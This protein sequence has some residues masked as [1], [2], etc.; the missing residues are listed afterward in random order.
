MEGEAWENV[1]DFLWGQRARR[2]AIEVSNFNSVSRV[3]KT[4]NVVARRH[5]FRRLYV[6]ELLP[7]QKMRT[8]DMLW[9]MVERPEVHLSVKFLS[10]AG[11]SALDDALFMR[12]SRRIQPTIKELSLASCRR[13]TNT[14]AFRIGERYRCLSHLSFENCSKLST[15]GVASAVER[16]KRTLSSLNVSGIALGDRFLRLSLPTLQS[17]REFKANRCG[18][19]DIM[20][21]TIAL[22]ELEHLELLYLGGNAITT[23]GVI[24]AFEARK[25]P[26]SLSRLISIDLSNNQ[27]VTD[28]AL[29]CVAQACKRIAHVNLSQTPITHSSLHVLTQTAACLAS[30][31]IRYCPNVDS[32]HASAL[33][34]IAPWIPRVIR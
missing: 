2:W 22:A 19:D 8:R 6:N 12:I 4:L 3:S 14:S 28:E 27:H 23:D 30:L 34:F 5:F 11:F 15:V 18:I 13:I 9:T 21:A 1:L 32:T 16:S 29:V 26:R 7:T 20:L 24:S 17:L 31:D 10:L 33:T 25:G